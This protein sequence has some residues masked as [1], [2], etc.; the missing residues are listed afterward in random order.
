MTT[1]KATLEDGQ[2]FHFTA[3]LVEA[4]GQIWA[5]FHDLDDDAWQVTPFQTADAN[6]SQMRAAELL[7]EYF[8]NGD[9]D[10]TDV[11]TV[12]EA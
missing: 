7:A 9:D 3:D 11:E 8:A 4:S 1:Y 12:R 10:C 6:H 2:T 5:N